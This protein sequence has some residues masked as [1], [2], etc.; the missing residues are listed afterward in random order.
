MVGRALGVERRDSRGGRG[1]AARRGRVGMAMAHAASFWDSTIR[2]RENRRP[3]ARRRSR[4]L[5]LTRIEQLGSKRGALRPLFIGKVN[6]ALQMAL[7]TLAVSEPA[8]AAE[9]CATSSVLP[10]CELVADKTVRAALEAATA[11]SAVVATGEYARIFFSHRDSTPR[12][13]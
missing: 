2:T 8:F 13:V 5:I 1:V 4:V 10:L 6:T 9:T 7:V 3:R 11:V 12:D